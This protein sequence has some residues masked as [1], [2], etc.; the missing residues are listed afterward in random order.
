[1]QQLATQEDSDSEED[2]NI[3]AHT[4]H[5]NN[6]QELNQDVKRGS[7]FNNMTIQQEN[8][9]EQW[10]VLVDTGSTIISTISKETVQALSRSTTVCVQ[11]QGNLLWQYQYASSKLQGYY[12]IQV[13]QE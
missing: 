1:M 13:Q 12:G 3:F 4:M 11:T 6:N 7:R 2:V 5:N 8:Q 9:Q 10:E